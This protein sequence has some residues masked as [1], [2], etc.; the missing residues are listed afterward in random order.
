[1]ERHVIVFVSFGL[2]ISLRVTDYTGEDQVEGGH[3]EGLA[4]VQW[5]I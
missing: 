1:V 2:E 3:M 4:L 5:R